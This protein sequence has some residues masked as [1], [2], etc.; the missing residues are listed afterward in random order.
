MDT[1]HPFD[2]I[3][4]G[5]HN[6]NLSLRLERPCDPELLALL[7]QGMA[8]SWCGTSGVSRVLEFTVR[9][10]FDQMNC[11]GHVSETGVE[12]ATSGIAWHAVREQ[13]E[14]PTR[15]GYQDLQRSRIKA[16]IESRLD[17]PDLSLHAI[18]QGCGLSLRSVHRAFTVDPASSASNHIWMRRLGHCA[19]DLRD[20]RQ[21][22][23]PITDV[24]FSW[25]SNS[26]SHSGWLF[27]E[28]LG[29]TPR[30]HRVAFEGMGDV[31]NRVAQAA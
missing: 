27:M 21:E 15:L 26:T 31:G 25:G 28:N 20:C 24:C 12:L 16:F 17:D 22:H 5:A 4:L 7:E 1:R 23:R 13:L 30:E 6:E 29:V 19:A 14:A 8:R 11:L 2:I 10:T 18:A 3:S 9:E